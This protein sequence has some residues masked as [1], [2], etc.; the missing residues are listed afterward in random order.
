M[1]F[2]YYGETNVHQEDLEDFLTI[3]EELELNGLT[4]RTGNPNTDEK[5]EYQSETYIPAAVE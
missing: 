5:S 4:D 2:C 1:D 3:A